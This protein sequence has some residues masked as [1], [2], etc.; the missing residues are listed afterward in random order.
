MPG[1]TFSNELISRDE[2]LHGVRCV[3]L[4]YAEQEAPQA[5]GIRDNQRGSF[6]LKGSLRSVALPLI[7]MNSDMMSQYIEFVADRLIIQLGLTLCLVPQTH[8]HL[9]K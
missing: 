4:Q 3:A 6:R 9:W 8:S 5:E 1:L 7:G 2:A